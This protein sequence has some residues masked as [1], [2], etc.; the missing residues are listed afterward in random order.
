[1]KIKTNKKKE[2]PLAWINRI[3]HPLFTSREIWITLSKAVE[4]SEV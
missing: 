1:M 4:I 2:A 3:S